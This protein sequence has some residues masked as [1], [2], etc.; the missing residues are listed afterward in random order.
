VKIRAQITLRTKKLG[1]LIRDARLASRRSLQDCAE[2]LGVTKGIFKS[3]EEGRRALS[4]PEL[5]ILAYFLNLPFGH[6]WG[7]RAMSEEAPPTEPLD[8][9]QLISLRQHMI[10][11][12]LRHARMAADVSIKSLAEQTGISSRRLNSY[13]LG[14]RGVPLPELEVIISALNL[15]I[16]PFFDQN[17]PVGQWL[18]RQKATQRFL[19]LPADLRDFV[20]QPVNRPYLELARDLS[21]LPADRLRSV[22]EGLLEITL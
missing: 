4:L 16:E 14:R 12:Q 18:T 10:G 15:E 9:P 6:F 19:D 21:K 2:V 1:V 13:E 20:S 11:T 7:D 3:Y 22:A 17:G 8:L 5:E